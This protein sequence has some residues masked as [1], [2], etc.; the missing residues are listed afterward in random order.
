M[1]S[2]P[3]VL[4]FVGDRFTTVEWRDF[5]R[6]TLREI[7][8]HPFVLKVHGLYFVGDGWGTDIGK[9]VAKKHPNKVRHIIEWLEV[10]LPYWSSDMMD[11][12]LIHL[13]TLNIN[14]ANPSEVIERIQKIIGRNAEIVA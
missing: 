2:N 3:V 9:I 14:Q 4:E 10:I 5:V 8:R 1:N 7:T 12:Q 6:L 13:P 11:K